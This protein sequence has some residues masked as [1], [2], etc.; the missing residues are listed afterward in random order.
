MK[1]TKYRIT[2]TEME[3]GPVEIIIT[4]ES[5]EDYDITGLLGNMFNS[6]DLEWEL[7]G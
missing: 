1:I 5:P 2:D 6:Y 7:L 4:T 3:E